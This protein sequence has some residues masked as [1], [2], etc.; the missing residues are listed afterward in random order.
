MKNLLYILLFVPFAFFAQEQDPCYSINDYN[1]LTQ[2]ANLPVSLDLLSGWNIMG[3]SCLDEGDALE[4][5]SPI[6]DMIIL[7]KNNAGSVYMPEFGFNGIGNLI[8]NQGYQ[9]KMI[10]TVLGFEMCTNPIPFHQVEGCTDCEAINFNRWATSDDG[11]CHYNICSDPQA[12]NYQEVLPCIYYGCND[13]LAANY[14]PYANT[15][16]GSCVVAEACPYEN[17]LEY[18]PDAISYNAN[19]CINIIVEGCTDNTAVNYNSDANVDD[20]SCEFIYGCIDQEADNY[21]AEP[22]TDNGSCIYYG[23]MD[24][25]AGNYDESANTDDGSCLIGGCVIEIAE[26]YN[27]EAQ[28][29]DGSCIVFGC[30]LEDFPNYNEWANVDNGS[31]DMTSTDVFGCTDPYSFSYNSNANIDNGDC[32]MIHVGQQAYGGIVF[33]VDESGTSGL[34]AAAEDIGQFEWG[35]YGTDINGDY[36][37]LSPELEVIGAGQQNTLEIVSGCSETP[38][39]ASEALAYESGVYSDWYLPS[40]DELELMYNTIGQGGPEGNIGG[41]EYDRYWSSTEHYSTHALLFYFHLGYL[42]ST[43]KHN[44]VR[45][46]VIRLF[47]HSL[48][49]GCMDE[50]ACNYNPEA[51]EDNGSCSYP[52]LGYDCDGNITEYIVGMEA[53]GGIVFYVD[54]TGEHGLV[55]A[56]E[57]L[58][59]K[60]GWGCQGTSISGAD[61]TV[62]GTGYQNTLDIVAGC[63]E[64][65]T[66]ASASLAYEV[67]NYIDWY[68]PSKGELNLMYYSIGQGSETGNIGN[69]MDSSYWSSSEFENGTNTDGDAWYVN[70]FTNFTNSNPIYKNFSTQVRPIRSF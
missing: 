41:F 27:S 15:D 31:C 55:A 62:I 8:P 43:N 19:L 16:D 45:A 40:L 56:M 13:P 47:Q 11:S 66:A 68:L 48:V 52:N 30:L 38:I 58:P 33:Y 61:G 17:Y 46:R 53:E 24:P 67:E 51:L 20:N 28:I 5:L 3:Y 54:S 18:S 7:A 25:T 37:N 9:I 21:N 6:S 14:D 12:D 2:E 32:D 49:S 59:D 63:A 34:V 23:C 29:N 35:C 70:F 1:I 26:N 60:Y 50:T 57:N 65:P 64:S 44:S 4:L 42:D 10:E 22:T 69:F 39:A 36:S